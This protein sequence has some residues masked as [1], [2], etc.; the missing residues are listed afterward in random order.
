MNGKAMAIKQH[1]LQV[2]MRHTQEI[3]SV[4]IA[5]AIDCMAQAIVRKHR[6]TTLLSVVGIANGGIALGKWLAREL[7][8]DGLPPVPYGTV[9]ILFHRDDLRH[10]PIPKITFPTDLPFDIEGA[11]I[12]LADDVLFTGRTVRAAINEIFD[13][14]RPHSIELAVLFDRASHCLPFCPDYCGFCKLV[15]EDKTVYTRLDQDNPAMNNIH[16]Q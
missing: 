7:I 2:S 16:I 8:R 15:P 3:D 13:Q 1:D 4:A 10:K 12:I 5:E 14:G 6:Q 11:T 9:D